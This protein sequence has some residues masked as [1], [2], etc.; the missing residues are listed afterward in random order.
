MNTPHFIKGGR[1][2]VL[3]LWVL[4]LPDRLEHARCHT[5]CRGLAGGKT[6]TVTP[7]DLLGAISQR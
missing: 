7:F 6:R 5:G 3:L 2:I 4:A 1:F